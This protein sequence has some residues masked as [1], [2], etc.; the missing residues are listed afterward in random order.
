VKFDGGTAEDQTLVIGSGTF[1]PGFEEQLVGMMPGESKDIN[2]TFPENY[3]PDLQGKDAVFAITIKS[4]RERQLPDLDDEFAKDISEF[5]TL[6]ELKEDRRRQMQEYAD[7]QAQNAMDDEALRQAA[8][9]AEIDIPDCMIERQIDMVIQDLTYQLAMSGLS[10][11]DYM[12][13]S[14]NTMESIRNDYREEAA[15]QVRM[16]LVLEAIIKAE[17]LEATEEEMNEELSKFA[18]QSKK[19]VDEVRATFSERDLDYF[20]D[21]ILERKA[22]QLITESVVYK[23]KEEP[24]KVAYPAAEEGEEKA[25]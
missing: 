4:V 1:I 10:I 15:T 21:R 12:K 2:V 11:D 20:K 22:L 23:E 6:E 9:N 13:F 25:E 8:N 18:E 3:Q 24:K 16:G 5:D 19:T 17:N 14:G 7:I